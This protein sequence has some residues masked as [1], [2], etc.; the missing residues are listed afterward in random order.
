M[1]AGSGDPLTFLIVTNLTG[2]GLYLTF[3]GLGCAL[4][5]L[6]TIA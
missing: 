1:C 5:F 6:T 3:S 4:Y 2:S